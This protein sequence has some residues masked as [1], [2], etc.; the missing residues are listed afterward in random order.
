MPSTP[1]Y[2][3]L[4][5]QGSTFYAFPSS[6]MHSN[7]KFTKFTLLNIPNRVDNVK[8]TTPKGRLDFDSEDFNSNNMSFD[9]YSEKLGSTTQY[10]DSL[11][12]SLRNYV[13]NHDTVMRNSKISTTGDFYNI[14]EI[15]TPTEM[16]FWKWLRKLNVID[17]EV[18]EH[19]VDW[20]KSS[21]D[22]DNPNSDTLT[23]TD[24][25]RKLLWTERKTTEYSLETILS[26]GGNVAKVIISYAAKFRVGDEVIFDGDGLGDDIIT[27]KSYVLTAVE[28]GEDEDGD[29]KTTIYFIIEADEDTNPSGG[30]NVEVTDPIGTVKLDYQQVVKYIG[31]INAMSDVRTARKDEVEIT[32]YIPHQ[33]GSTP[34]VL[35]SS[36]QDENYYPG[37]ELPI[38]S[39]QLQ[40]EIVG[41][42]N[43]D[44]PIRQNPGDYP[45]LYYG[46]FDSTNKS[47]IAASGDKKR[48]SG[49]YY[50]VNRNNN[51]GIDDDDFN[52]LMTEF[53][54]T[55][56]DG[57]NVDFNLSHYLKMTLTNEDVGFN[58]DEFNQMTIDNVEPQDFEYNAILWYYEVDGDDVTDTETYT[59]LY[60]ITILNNP[61]NNDSDNTLIEPYQKLVSNDEHDGFS[62]IHTLNLSTSVDNDTSSMSF[63][64]ISLNNTFGF[65]LYSNVMSNLGKLNESFTNIISTFTTMNSDISDMKSIIYT[66]TD[67]DLI[68]AKL[69]NLETLL[70]LYEQYQF[71]NSD[72]VSITNNF[73]GTYPTISFNVKNSEYSS[74][75]NLTTSMIYD[76]KVSSGNDYNIIIPES[77]KLFIKITN[78]DVTNYNTLSILLNSDLDYKQSAE[79]YIDSDN[80]FYANNLKIK[81]NYDS[82]TD[83]YDENTSS[84]YIEEVV[85]IDN[86]YLPTDIGDYVTN[87]IIYNRTYYN[88]TYISHNINVT[89][90]EG[91]A[92]NI[93]TILYPTEQ[94]IMGNSSYKEKVYIDNFKFTNDLTGDLVDYSGVYEINTTVNDFNQVYFKV[95]LNTYDYTLV[96]I[97]KVFLPKAIK[98]TITRIDESAT[99]SLKDRYLI[100]K[101]YL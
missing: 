84:G 87:N 57:I 83:G 28:E 90:S 96:S 37:L 53:D 19:S 101:T 52:F 23:E 16:I 50:G 31:E 20:D 98:Y 58:F 65:D 70:Q 42:E 78:D 99:S 17:F 9:I 63:D 100:Q 14:S 66:Q 88:D 71:V 49:N 59:N 44:S 27:G 79:I 67:M 32:A 75:Y 30:I 8:G 39:S 22:Y 74:V 43:L 25:F 6:S 3:K 55:T 26:A 95:L 12:E 60:G 47:Y 2:K 61:K 15:Q 54:S 73:S 33:A 18:A 24:Y 91:D 81:M 93:Y 45:G 56:L 10:Q 76:Y 40:T 77:N 97:P 82:D 36:R 86:L 35:F 5:D 69:S 92:P 68:K 41:A 72:T 13:A 38:L 89:K 21:V 80:G 48:Y 1:L 34:T 64:P 94:N 62:Y 46:Q 11:I 51:V 4:K 7:P 85:L 29:D